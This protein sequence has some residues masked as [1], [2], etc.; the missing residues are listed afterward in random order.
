MVFF[1]SCVLMTG[2]ALD[3]RADLVAL[4]LPLSDEP[5]SNDVEVTVTAEFS[6]LPWPVSDHD[7]STV[8][9]MIDATVDVQFDD[10]GLPTAVT[11]ITIHDTS[12]LQL[13]D[14]LLRLPRLF[15]VLRLE[16]DSL[17][18]Q[19]YTIEP[20]GTVEQDGLFPGEEHALL[21][22]TG[23]MSASGSVLD[24]PV[25][26]DFA[27]APAEISGPSQ[28]S[29]EIERLSV[30]EG[31]GS[32]AATFRMNLNHKLLIPDDLPPE[33]AGDIPEGMSG[34]LVIEGEIVG[35]A[36]FERPIAPEL[37]PVISISPG[38][39]PGFVTVVI[40]SRAG[41]RYR[42]LKRVML[43]ADSGWATAVDEIIGDGTNIS[44]VIETDA[45]A[46]LFK[47]ERIV[48]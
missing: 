8:S 36:T 1:F 26:F 47:A 42:L 31:I 14:L 44:T 10:T 19:M 25:D 20:P 28:G 35:Y 37:P 22:N 38:P 48:D 32:Y 9:G 4:A 40:E 15:P 18:G 7:T 46:C 13:S 21:L 45:E 39:V 43:P 34:S 17:G 2:P 24:E 16:T 3:S 29:I 41:E 33:S 6:S 12:T 30:S 27:T 5:G 23:V 11:A